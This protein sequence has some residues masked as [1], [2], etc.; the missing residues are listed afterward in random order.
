[1]NDG[2]H[3]TVLENGGK[4]SRNTATKPA[5]RLPRCWIWSKLNKM[6]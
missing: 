3:Y 5:N 6:T 2:E 4:K 1:M